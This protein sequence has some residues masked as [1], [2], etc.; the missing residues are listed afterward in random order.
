MEQFV[1]I[2]R[3]QLEMELHHRPQRNARLR[4]TRL[5][6]DH[7]CQQDVIGLNKELLQIHAL[8]TP[9]AHATSSEVVR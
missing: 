3:A 8:C 4:T 5:D 9:V 1:I 6:A 7:P 2:F